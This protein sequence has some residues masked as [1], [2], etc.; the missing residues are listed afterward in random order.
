MG[1]DALVAEALAALAEEDAGMAAEAEAALAGLLAGQEL[2]ALTQAR[3]QAFCWQELPATGSGPGHDPRIVLDALARVLVLL[4]LERYA[5]LCTSPTTVSVLAAHDEGW[6]EGR[7]A[8]DAAAAASGIVPVDLEE[9]AW[10]PVRGPVEVAA[11]DEASELL[12]LA[13]AVGELRPGSPGWRQA[14]R[15][16]L[17]RHLGGSE[18]GA[19]APRIDGIRSERLEAWLEGSRSHS[20]RHLLDPVATDL[21]SPTS[22][23]GAGTEVLE[24]L[25]W[26]L[27]ELVEGQPL[28]QAGNLSRGF[29]QRAAIRFGWEATDPGL[30]PRSEPELRDLHLVRRLA[31]RL[32]LAR[33]SRRGLHLTVRGRRLLAG[34]PEGFWRLVAAGLLPADEYAGSVGE[35][36]LAMLLAGPTPA[37]AMATAAREVVDEQGWRATGTGERPDDRAIAWGVR[38]TLELL[39]ALAL[40]EPNPDEGA[41]QVLTAGGRVTA[42]EALHRRATAP[43]TR[44]CEP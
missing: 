14:Q 30:L 19:P 3:V 15:A 38:A 11:H 10:G 12:E 44:P 23:P 25:R 9:L 33:R 39:R 32:A 40:V 2:A 17:R 6:D 28:T 35:I 36:V 34:D 37:R 4:G 26:L 41:A 8:A 5:G 27:G 43:R 7:R 22:W 16:L 24:P 21:A 31:E 20:R 29:V 18:P 42:R 1:T 13:V